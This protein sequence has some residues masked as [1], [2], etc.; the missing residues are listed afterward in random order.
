MHRPRAL[1]LV[2]CFL[3]ASVLVAG[4]A[5]AS[6]APVDPVRLSAYAGALVLAGALE[7]T[8]WRFSPMTA[9]PADTAVFP[10]S[11]TRSV[12]I[13][14]LVVRAALYAVINAL[15]SSGNA[16]VLF[17]L[18]PLTAYFTV[19][20]RVAYTLAGGGLLL[21]GILVVGRPALRAN[22]EALS[23][24][25]ML[26]IGVVF[27]LAI[28]VI[29]EREETGRRRAES[30]L[31]ELSDA[32]AQ[33]R[34]YADQ[35]VSLA[36]IAERTRVARD[37]HDSVGHHLVV[38]AIQLEKSAAYRA[39]DADISDRALAEGRNSAR[40]ALDE[41][42]RAVG[43]LRT[44]GTQFTLA[45]S[46]RALAAR[47]DDTGFAVTLDVT[48][49]EDS[50]REPARLALYLAAQEALINARRHSGATTVAVRVDL[51]PTAGVLDIV[52]N[53]TGFAP[54]TV[55]GQGLSGMR[56]R[57]DMVGGDVRITSGPRGTRL[58]ATIPAVRR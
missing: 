14:G 13:A 8:E 48:G 29:A 10:G 30:L 52:D 50:V 56:E 2:A 26:T 58:L 24:L 9:S 47:L 38:T 20:H 4:L 45:A 54:G 31:T 17:V 22:P 57:L 40:M 21:A 3:Y 36:T 43:T 5:V 42:R 51:T 35:A 11:A 12:A 6:T 55:E 37:I 1:T 23:D 39:L 44:D 53:G 15:D 41:V 18:L 46:L 33:L 34:E 32:H 16:K 28:A 49:T 27:A 25:L 7:I 19:G